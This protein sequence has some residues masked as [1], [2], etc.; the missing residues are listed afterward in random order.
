MLPPGLE[1]GLFFPKVHLFTIQT[2]SNI[3][4]DMHKS[5]GTKKLKVTFTM[6]VPHQNKG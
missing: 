3:R 5:A 2:T 4:I 1:T 6:K